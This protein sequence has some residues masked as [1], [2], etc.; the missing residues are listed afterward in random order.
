[1]NTDNTLLK[2]PFF[3]ADDCDVLK[4]TFSNNKLSCG[5]PS[6]AQNDTENKIDLFRKLIKHPSTTFFCLVEGD[7]ME[8]AG[9]SDGDI[10]IIDKSLEPADGSI[11]MAYIDGAF[12]LK[13][14]KV[15]KATK[16]VWLVPE[17]EKYK[18]IKITPDNEQFL[19][20]GILIHV[21]KSFY[22]DSPGR[23][24]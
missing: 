3:R 9:I 10:A 1:M 6:P 22:H 5:F 11:A 4:I 18:P 16:T 12:T 2:E 14:L 15:D 19:V 23:C 7:S 20:W 24:K 13:R 17:N 21:I 8:N